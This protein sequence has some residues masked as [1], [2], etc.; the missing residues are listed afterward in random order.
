MSPTRLAVSLRISLPS[1]N[2]LTDEGRLSFRCRA[3][4]VFASP[5]SNL[6]PGFEHDVAPYKQPEGGRLGNEQEAY[7]V[8]LMVP[9]SREEATGTL[10]PMDRRQVSEA[11]KSVSV[12]RRE[13]VDGD[14]LR[15][16]GAIR[17]YTR[18]RDVEGSSTDG[19]PTLIEIR[20]F[21]QIDRPKIEAA[22]VDAI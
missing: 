10:E 16:L 20:K 18:K 21:G 12:N 6:A 17:P 9:E 11:R 15:D 19:P 3:A 1:G 2:L 14:R 8:E 5:S 7:I 13:S 4:R 22:T